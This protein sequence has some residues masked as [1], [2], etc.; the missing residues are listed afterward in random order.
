MLSKFLSH[1]RQNTG[2]RLTLG[3]TVIFMAGY[4]L[5]LYLA[6][7]L[8]SDSLQQ[9]D[10][11]LILAKITR[12]LETDE[13]NG[14]DFL[15]NQIQTDQD[16]NSKLGLLAQ[17][18]GTDGNTKLIT[19]PYN[20]SG[21]DTN[22]DNWIIVPQEG[23]WFTLTRTKSDIEEELLLTSRILSND[24]VLQIGRSTLERDNLVS[25]FQ[26]VIYRFM[27]PIFIFSILFGIMLAWH[28]LRP[29]RDLIK[30]VKQIRIG[31]MEARVP[32]RNPKSDLGELS[33]LFNAMLEKINTLI[34]S[35]KESLDNVA[36][37]LRTPLSRMKVNLELVL[38][39][40]KS[41]E[42]REETLINCVENVE[43]IN[44]ILNALLDITKAESGILTL[45]KEK[46]KVKLIIEEVLFLYDL[47]AE[48][49]EIKIETYFEDDLVIYA[50]KSRLKQ[51]I[52]NLIDNAIKYSAPKTSIKLTSFSEADMAVIEIH[53]QGIGI[54]TKE[55]QL[56]FDRL[57]RSDKS[58][59]QKGLGLGLSIVK[60]IVEAHE[61]SLEVISSP[62][63][64]SIF[65]IL[66]P[67][68]VS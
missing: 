35:M 2:V 36:H 28:S 55:H 43:Q 20:W 32:V 58:R 24:F 67:L 65:R 1:I 63:Q 68:M 59:S 25:N 16:E 64:G 9:K 44:T 23:L 57:Y 7:Y 37:D 4:I 38:S 21:L 47:V 56:I 11:T 12:Y 48:E 14:V 53:D 6:S 10:Q 52:A 29:I 19:T 33:G 42:E 54:D 13:K 49:K 27:V 61:G 17:I 5:L 60:A 39:T 46:E 45:N 50:D 62:G 31:D 34:K 40:E 30:T 51:V 66:L 15:I 3:F 8:L 41:K 18:T 22:L 26:E